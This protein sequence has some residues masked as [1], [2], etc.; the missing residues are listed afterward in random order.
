MHLRDER[1]EARKFLFVADFF[2]KGDF[3]ALAVKIT[4]IIEEE[5]FQTMMVFRRNHRIG[6]KI[7]DPI[8]DRAILARH[9]L[10]PASYKPACYR[11]H[12]GQSRFSA[13][14]FASE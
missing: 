10:E 5:D 7:G 8:E 9:S 3:K 2:D 11:K 12:A 13:A 14:H 6:A 1:I 4:R